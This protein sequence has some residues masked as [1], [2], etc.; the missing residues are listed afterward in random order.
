[1]STRHYEDLK[2][3][4]DRD[5]FVVLRNY[6]AERELHQM[7]VQLEY[8]HR[9]VTQ[10]RYRAIGTMKS[11]DKEHAWFR[12]YLEEGPHIPL[13][14][15]LLEDS[16][17]PDNVSWI[18]KPEGVTRTL[19]HFDALGSYRK[20][21]SGISLWI[22]MD[23]IDRGNGCTHYEKGSHRREFEYVYPLR[24]YDED[25]ANVFRLE[26]D[27][28]DAVMHSTKTVHWSVDPL[29]DRERNAMVFAYWAG[30]SGIDAVGAERSNSADKDGN[31]VL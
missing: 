16:L 30:S 24:D 20:S 14:K 18:A 28:G 11:M 12:H 15:F 25:N 31:T 10:Q 2:V 23:R 4:Y 22:A 19:P 27:P 17:S 7:R 9:E 26:V 1:M 8:V 5:G 3:E 29:D 6:L 13:M 21:S